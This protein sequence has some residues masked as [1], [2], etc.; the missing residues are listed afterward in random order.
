[1]AG[2][3]K[4][5]EQIHHKILQLRK[6]ETLITKI[7]FERL[8]NDSV[9]TDLDKKNIDVWTEK[10]DRASIK[11]WMFKHPSLILGELTSRRL[12]EIARKLCIEN[13][14]RKSKSQLIVDIRE[15]THV[16]E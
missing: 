14:P 6:M 9:T 7:E 11:R 3:L 4:I 2:I 12:K 8:Y 16:E 15:K 5:Q 13:W 1:M 10:L